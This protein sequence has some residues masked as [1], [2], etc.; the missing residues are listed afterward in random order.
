MDPE[1][2]IYWKFPQYCVW[3]VYQTRN[4]KMPPKAQN[5]FIIT[6]FCLERLYNI[7]RGFN[8][9]R[10]NERLNWMPGQIKIHLGYYSTFY[11]CHM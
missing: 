11:R 4:K 6:S 1:C 8:C 2:C 10:E 7:T 5:K 9:F 3:S